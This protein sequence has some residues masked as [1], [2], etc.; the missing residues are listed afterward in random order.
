MIFAPLPN[1]PPLTTP[2]AKV[3]GRATG[4]MVGQ[5][6]AN[7]QEQPMPEDHTISEESPSF[8]VADEEPDDGEQSATF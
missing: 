6:V 1:A 4:R 7:R 2:L 3:A 8:S 5:Y